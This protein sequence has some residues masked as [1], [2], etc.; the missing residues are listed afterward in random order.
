MVR[1]GKKW[2][3]EI[4]MEKKDKKTRRFAGVLLWLVLLTPQGR[5][6]YLSIGHMSKHMLIGGINALPYSSHMPTVHIWNLIQV[7]AKMQTS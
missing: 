2:G 6:G 5:T 1:A 4:Y 7:S 3:A